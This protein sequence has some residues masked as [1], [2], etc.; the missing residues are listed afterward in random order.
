MKNRVVTIKEAMEIL[1]MTKPGLYLHI[2]NGLKVYY[3]DNRKT[4]SRITGETTTTTTLE[5]L[6][7]YFADRYKAN[8]RKAIEHLTAI[9]NA[10]Q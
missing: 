8:K 4:A 2:R 5:D 3:E 10:M 6:R 9:Y 7:A 1:G